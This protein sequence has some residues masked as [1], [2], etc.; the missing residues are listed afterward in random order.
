MGT[1]DQLS[2]L[3]GILI[4]ANVGT[5]ATMLYGTGRV[6]WWMAKLEARVEHLEH[7]EKRREEA[8]T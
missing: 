4:M 7:A 1:P 6:I 3:V 2:S 5:I 8:L